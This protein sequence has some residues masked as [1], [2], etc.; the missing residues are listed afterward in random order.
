MLLLACVL[1]LATGCDRVM[2]ARAQTPFD[3]R[4]AMRYV[5]AQLE[6]GPRV[7][8]SEA[9]RRAGDWIAEQMRQRSD[10][11]IEQR[12]THVTARGDTLPLRNI[13]ARIRPESRQRILYIAHWD[14]RPMAERDPTRRNRDLPIDG[15]N[16]GASGVA[17]LIGVAD[18]LRERAPL[19]GVDLLF[20]DGEDY[21][22][23]G[24]DRDVLL[25]SRWFVENLPDPDFR[26]LFGVVWDMVGAEGATFFQEAN[27]VERAPEVVARVWQTAAELGHSGLFV[28]RV[29]AAITDDHVPFLDAGFRVI[30]VIDIDDRGIR[31]LHHHRVSDTADKLSVG[32]LQAAGDV[33]VALVTER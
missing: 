4:A 24:A 30:D 9:H 26:P 18:A 13:L 3:G 14:T 1:M 27:S 12:W 32:T 22:D 5:E 31:Y 7:P 23:F 15:A 28:R 11:V 10:T 2:P 21:G 17:L 8:G 6:F 19:Y 20:V 33:A 29:G 25:G 16:D